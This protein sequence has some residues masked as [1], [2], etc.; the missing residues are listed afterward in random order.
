M[1]RRR[2]VRDAATEVESLAIEARELL[3]KLTSDGLE[4]RI[5]FLGVKDALSFCVKLPDSLE[6]S[7]DDVS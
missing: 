3:A 4:V 6:V 1:A 7:H 2:P 5:D